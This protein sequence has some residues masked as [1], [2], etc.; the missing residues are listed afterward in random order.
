MIH[1]FVFTVTF[2]FALSK[3]LCIQCFEFVGWMTGR[4]CYHTSEPTLTP[5]KAEC[6]YVDGGDL[7]GA[8]WK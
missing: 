8:R 4:V 6:W 1:Y 7:T 5:V 3:T 2:C